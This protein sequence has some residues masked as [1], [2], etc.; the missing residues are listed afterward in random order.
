MAAI[1]SAGVQIRSEDALA[2][3]P[4]SG[5]TDYRADQLIFGPDLPSRC[6]HLVVAGKVRL[7]R[8]CADGSEVLLDIVL[9]DEMFGESA[10]LNIPNLSECATAIGKTTVMAWPASELEDLVLRRPRLG[11]ALLQILA[12]RNL[13]CSRQIESFSLDNTERRLARVLIRFSERMGVTEDDGSVRMMPFTHEALSRYVGTS[14]EI[15]TQYMNRFRKQ[16]F[17][18]YSRRGIVVHRDSLL[19]VIQPLKTTFAG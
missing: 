15:V 3:L 11:V 19:T 7:S 18:S 6:M 10:F 8:R 12:E 2:Y 4:V 13:E 14:R 17:V 9:P 16:G 5:A 1:T